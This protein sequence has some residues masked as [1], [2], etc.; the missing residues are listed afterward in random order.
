MT[1]TKTDRCFYFGCWNQP[2]H[3]LFGHVSYTE[4]KKIAYYGAGRHL[5]ATLAPR[6]FHYTSELT[7]IGEHAQEKHHTISSK[8]E[9]CPQ[10]QYLRHF[11]D[12]GFT[13]VQWW[14]R[15]QGDT[16][17]ACN[18]TI[19]LEGE[20]TAE[21]VLAAGRVNFP[22]VFENLAKAGVELV[23]ARP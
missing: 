3:Y 21:E 6:R 23:E 16:R 2:G 8:T 13:A 10:G 9:E 5:D 20:H 17:G 19:L 18:S 11:L 7:W 14:D 12:N 4:E 15:T 1:E 22:T